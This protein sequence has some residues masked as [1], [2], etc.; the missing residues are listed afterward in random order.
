MLFCKMLIKFLNNH[1]IQFCIN[2]NIIIFDCNDIWFV[3]GIKYFHSHFGK[4]SG[5]RLWIDY[6][7]KNKYRTDLCSKVWRVLKFHNLESS[8]IPQFRSSKENMLISL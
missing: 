5:L 2:E 1:Y 4:F 3:T 7:K 8:K 6:C